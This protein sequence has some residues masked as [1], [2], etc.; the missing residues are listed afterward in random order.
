M[1]VYTEVDDED[2]SAFISRYDVGALVAYKG[3]AEGVENTNYLVQ[4]KTGRYILTLYEKRVARSDLP[5]FLRLMEHLS[6]RGVSCPTPVRDRSGTCLGELSGRAAAMVTFLDGFSIHR[7]RADHCGA[8]GEALAQFH[9]AGASFEPRRANALGMPSWR[10][11]FETLTSSLDTIDPGLSLLIADELAH[12]NDTWPSALPDGIIHADLFPDNVFFLDDKL[13]GLIDFYF[14]C[15]DY[16]AYDVAVCLNAWCF[17][18]DH[19]FDHEKGRALLEG[20]E[21]VRT[22]TK[23]ERDALPNLARGAAVRFLLT[24][25]HDWLHRPPNALVAPHDPMDY[26]HRLRFHRTVHTIA[27]YGL[28]TPA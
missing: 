4:T 24:R 12:I 20:Y 7:P 25:S 28:G 18:P 21:R 13:S 10:A 19:V 15:N 5:F 8:V 16:L 14:A 26:I 17:G 6:G 22:L 2:L 27:G 11:L 9:L 1:A 3:I 23:D